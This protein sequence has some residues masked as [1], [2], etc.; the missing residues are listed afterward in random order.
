[1]R[2]KKKVCVSVSLCECA[3]ESE[4]ESAAAAAA[5][6]ECKTEW[7]YSRARA[8]SLFATT[9]ARSLLERARELCKSLKVKVETAPSSA[10]LRAR[11]RAR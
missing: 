9:L 4:K 1:M 7:A 8:F 11:A 2:T 6:V 3:E 10:L 5:A